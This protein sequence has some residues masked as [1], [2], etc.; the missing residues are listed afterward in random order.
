MLPPNFQTALN[1]KI[2]LVPRGQLTLNTEPKGR[3]QNLKKMQVWC[4]SGTRRYFWQTQIKQI[5]TAIEQAALKHTCTHTHKEMYFLDS[6]AIIHYSEF[7]PWPCL[8]NFPELSRLLL[9]FTYLSS[10]DPQSTTQYC[11][12]SAWT[13]IKKDMGRIPFPTP[14]AWII[15]PGC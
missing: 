4:F 11:C 12:I 13:W 6:L 15:C 8:K 5:Q 3:K 14:C 9:I 7:S 10:Y 1:R 2:A